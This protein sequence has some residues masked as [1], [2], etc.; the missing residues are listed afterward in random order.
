MLLVHEIYVSIQGEST[1][2][3]RPCVFVRLSACD[4]RCTWCDT[5]YA[6][7]GGTKM[8]IDEV[9]AAVDEDGVGGWRVDERAGLR[10][11]DLDVVGQQREGGVR[12]SAG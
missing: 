10:R 6:F 1:H 3:G 5:T 2:A 9:V 7:T 4:L 12:I 11:E 8:S